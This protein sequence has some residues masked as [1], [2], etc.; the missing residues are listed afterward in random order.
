MKKNLIIFALFLACACQV[1]A[2]TVEEQYRQQIKERTEMLKLTEKMI[3]TKC[4]KQA[5]KDAK[6]DKKDG[7]KPMPGERALEMQY[8]EKLR[9]DV[10]VNSESGVPIY[11]VGSG[12]GVSVDLQTAYD[13][14]KARV[15]SDI[16]E[17]FKI[18]FDQ[19]IDESVNNQL[20]DTDV[21]LMKK[22]ISESTQY[23]S[24]NLHNIHHIV[25]MYRERVDGKYEVKV[26]SC[27]DFDQAKYLLFEKMELENSE[28]RDRLQR[29]IEK[30]K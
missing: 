2:Q 4:T 13:M 8:D 24:Q 20:A 10:M 9:K 16:A 21:H 7:W 3:N 14:S 5:K 11:I 19:V 15:V 27:V 23:M 30:H 12:S 6:R 17:H 28:V 22:Y 26:F 18:E 29:I 25:K 1:S